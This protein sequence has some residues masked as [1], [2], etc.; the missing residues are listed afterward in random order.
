MKFSLFKEY[1]MKPECSS[2]DEKNVASYLLVNLLQ[3]TKPNW[4][5]SKFAN[6]MIF[7]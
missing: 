4:T 3:N 1:F 5:F 2:L 7:A 6:S